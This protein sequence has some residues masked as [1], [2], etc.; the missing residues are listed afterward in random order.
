M[1]GV[2]LWLFTIAIYTAGLPCIN[3][4]PSISQFGCVRRRTD[5][6]VQQVPYWL[7][8]M[9]TGTPYIGSRISLV[10][11]AEIRYEG[12]LYDVDSKDATVT[13]SKGKNVSLQ[14]HCKIIIPFFSNEKI[15]KSFGTENRQ[16]PKQIPPRNEV[17]EY[18]IFRGS[19]IKDLSVSE[20]GNKDESP[21]LDPAI[22]SA[23]CHSK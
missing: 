2:I 12:I 4:V 21:H 5:E 15:V 10:S 1:R 14:I 11:K 22:V 6:R 13:L 17:Y 23:V 7:V 18:I 20:L 3:R 16:A 9:T 8:T 19:D